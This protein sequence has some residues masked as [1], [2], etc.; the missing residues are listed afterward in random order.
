MKTAY[1][2]VVVGAG[3]AGSAAA[4]RAAE[5]GLDVLMI[6]KRQEI[7]VPVRCGEATDIGT[8]E[9]FIPLDNRWIARR[10]DK[11]AV[12]NAQGDCVV[13]PPS[14]DT[15]ILDRKVFDAALAQRAAHMGA[16]VRA[17]A[18]AVGLLREN[19]AV[20][21]V[22]IKTMGRS[23]DVR[24]KLVVAADGT[25]SQ[26]ARWA[27][28]KTIPPLADFYVG[29][30]FTLTGM[31]RYITPD[32]CEYH[33][34]NETVAPGGY[35]WVFP[36][37]EETANVGIVISANRAR[38]VSAQTWLERFVERHYPGTSILS[39]V[40]GGIPITGAIKQMVT[41][42]L[43]VIGDAA[44]QA[45]PLTAG[46]ISLGMMGAEMAME[47][48]VPAIKR[49]DV[50]AKALRGYEELWKE[51]FGK[52]HAAL[53]AV[54]RILTRMDEK[55][56]DALIRKAATLPIDTMTPAAFV[57]ELLKTHPALLLEARTLITTGLI[58]K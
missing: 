53:L 39:V 30:Q 34:G 36:K 11:Y 41:D 8:T 46:G 5:G 19:G 57:L 1:D 50:S 27:G 42:G 47:V 45:D 9:R 10:I 16:E 7:G 23:Y 40:A 38:E 49:G 25:E 12:Y 31:R 51:R 2:V 6:E 17:S 33:V 3:P 4:I 55:Q 14:S 13:V 48:A 15:I 29:L 18:T 56:F 26:V 28:L 20:S 24:A 44:H 37:D 58:L 54:R 52:M 43:M 35:V 22:K 32:F 21:G